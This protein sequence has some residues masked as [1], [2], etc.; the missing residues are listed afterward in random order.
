[1][2]NVAGFNRGFRFSGQKHICVA[3]KEKAPREIQT[4]KTQQLKENVYEK[5][6]DNIH[7]G[8]AGACLLC[9]FVDSA[10]S[11]A[12]NAHPDTDCHPTTR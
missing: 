12:A 10:G 4:L 5:S 8:S 9:C 11:T 2:K 3:L 6:K 1:M 7:I